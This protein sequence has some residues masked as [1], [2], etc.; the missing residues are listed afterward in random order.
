MLLVFSY[1]HAYMRDGD[2][3]AVHQERRPLSMLK[4]RPRREEGARGGGEE[5]GELVKKKWQL[6]LIRSYERE[7]PAGHPLTEA[8]P[9][10]E[11]KFTGRGLD[12]TWCHWSPS[13]SVCTSFHV[14]PVRRGVF[15]FE[16]F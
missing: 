7:K 14:C 6:C 13:R 1:C 3:S 10:L 8:Q 11:L 2:G 15:V 4:K 12:C 9:Y 16:L 5:E